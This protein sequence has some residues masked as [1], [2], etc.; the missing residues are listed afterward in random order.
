ME[1][2]TTTLTFE[3]SEKS[4]NPKKGQRWGK[5]VSYMKRNWPLY[6]MLVPMFIYFLIFNYYPMA[7]I[8][9]A[10]KK[11]TKIGQ[12]WGSPWC[13]DSYGN[14]DLFKNF[15]ELFENPDFL[16]VFKNTLRIS[17]LRILIG[18]PIPIILTIL[19]NEMPAKRYAKTFQIVSYLPHFISWVI[20]SGIL[21]SLTQS[22]S[23]FQ[24]LMV[25]IFGQEA[26]FFNTPDLF[27]WL[28]IFTNIWK[29]A[30]W[31]T[32]IYF[33]ALAGINP[34]L[35]EAADID[36]ASR[37][38]K[39]LHITLPGLIPAI[40]INLILTASGFVHAGF[41]Q[42]Y[43]LY[44]P[45]VYETSDIIET[46]LFRKGITNG[47]YDMATALGLFNSTISLVLVL[48]SNKIIKWIGGDSIW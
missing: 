23:S 39:M 12:I 38:N 2:S 43:N 17:S 37:W 5:F 22:Y 32:I 41:D 34:D 13:T 40:S 26:L 28:L 6:L 42:I 44:N 21:K 20:I 45:T 15:R 31:G 36:G 10:F 1:R 19:L 24:N 35:Y 4:M 47:K 33:A 30:G 3:L 46:Y 7:G 9:L 18:F 27:L 29:S 11:W 14:L 48:I 16:V 8:Q 25:K